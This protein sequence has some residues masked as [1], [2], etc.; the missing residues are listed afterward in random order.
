MPVN[1]VVKNIQDL[2]ALPLRVSGSG[3]VYLRDVAEISDGTD[4]V[5][6]YALVNGRRTVF[7]PVTK[8]ADASIAPATE[9]ALQCSRCRNF[10]RSHGRPK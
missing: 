4:L 5:T 2:A 6:S 10:R 8:R 7:I 3:A 9:T 1:S